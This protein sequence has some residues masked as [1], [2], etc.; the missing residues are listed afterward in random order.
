MSRPATDS[1][2]RLLRA[3][4][5]VLEERGFSG[6]TL[7]AVTAKAKVNLGLVSYHFGG[8]K[9]FEREVAQDIYEGFFKDF[10]LEIEG[11]AHPVKALRAG[12]LRLA[13][14]ARDH[15]TLIR[16]IARDLML[17]NAEA[18]A[19]LTANAPRHGVV[20]GRL[21]RRCMAEG[22]FQQLPLLTVMPFAMGA[23]GAPVIIA[24]GLAKLAPQLPF[25]LTR[26]VVERNLLSDAALQG[27]VDLILKALKK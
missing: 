11:E 7:R 9:A 19:F 14:F 27:R 1:R 5:A 15:R 23:L 3:G 16:S 20:L 10:S 17:D 18:R 12:L 13:Y 24:D 2:E 21:M 22:H 26:L 25:G 6:L 8:K 4:R